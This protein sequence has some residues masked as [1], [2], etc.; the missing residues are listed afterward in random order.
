MSRK[1]SKN[2]K[3]TSII[4]KFEHSGKILDLIFGIVLVKRPTNAGYN[5]SQ[6]YSMN[7]R[8][9]N[10]KNLQSS[11]SSGKINKKLSIQKSKENE[12]KEKRMSKNLST[13]SSLS[14]KRPKQ[15]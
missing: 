9:T 11:R 12:F 1:K 10:L 13:N 5:M 3:N 2:R 4:N 14:Q 15:I 8:T 7:L 6:D